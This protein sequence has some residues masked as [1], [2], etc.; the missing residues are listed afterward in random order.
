MRDLL[1]YITYIV[2]IGDNVYRRVRKWLFVVHNDEIIINKV[3][4]NDVES[5]FSMKQYTSLCLYAIF[6]RNQ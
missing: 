5:V 3:S 2:Y 6:C 4:F 1:D